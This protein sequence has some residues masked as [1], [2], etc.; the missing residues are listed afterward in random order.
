MKIGLGFYREQL[1]RENFR[2]AVQAGATHVVAHLTN[3]FAGRDPK[4]YSGDPRHGWGDCSADR[5]WTYE[6]LAALVAALSAEGLKLAALENF[7]PRFWY[8]VLLDGPERAQQIEGLKQ[9]IRDAGRAGIPCI[10][11]NFSIAGVYGWTRGPYARGGA[12]SVGYGVAAAELGA[13]IPDVMVWN[14]L[15]LPERPGEQPVS[16]TESELWDRLARFLA[17]VI[18]VAEEAGVTLAAHPDDPPVDLLRGTPRLVN[19]PEKYDRLLSLVPSPR[20]GLELCLG[21][22]QEMPGGGIY[23]HVRRF[24]RSGRIGYIHFRN[25]RGKVPRYV[26]SFVDDGDIDMAEIVRILR[27]EAYDGVLIP[28]HT[29]EM[30]CD[31]SWHAGK[32]FALGYMKALVQNA[33]ALGPARH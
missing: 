5:L 24:A 21:S 2:F 12:N 18:P 23:D 13:P 27:D 19:R 14:M 26:E 20:N 1:H 17:D 15:Y 33:D 4:I 16:L 9:L 30:S 6:E 11:Y 10:G 29:P 8:D 28:D 22:L 32:A 7:S 25:V 31:A 3:Y